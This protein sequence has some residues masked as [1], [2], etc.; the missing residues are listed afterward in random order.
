MPKYPSKD[1]EVGFGRPPKGTRFKKGSSG[2]PTGRPTK[3]M[4]VSDLFERELAGKVTVNG[5]GGPEKMTKQELLIRSNINEAIKGRP[6]AFKWAMLMISRLKLDEH[7]QGWQALDAATVQQ[8]HD[9]SGRW[10]QNHRRKMERQ[11]AIEK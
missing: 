9:R 4:S 3:K 11:E 6:A 10:L 2:N 1:Y 8:L 7:N 5:P